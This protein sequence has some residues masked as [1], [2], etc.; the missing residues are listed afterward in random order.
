MLREEPGGK[1][2]LAAGVIDRSKARG[3]AVP[4]LMGVILPPLVREAGNRSEQQGTDIVAKSH[5]QL[6]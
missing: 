2:R 4:G 3:A 6:S 1:K 5:E